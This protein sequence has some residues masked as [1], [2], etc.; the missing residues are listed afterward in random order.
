M[1][2]AIRSAGRVQHG[3]QFSF[4]QRS[5]I[6]DIPFSHSL[7]IFTTTMLLVY[8]DIDPLSPLAS[9]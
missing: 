6:G 5:T 4:W 1:V 9:Y 2:S 3:T 7:I 8:T